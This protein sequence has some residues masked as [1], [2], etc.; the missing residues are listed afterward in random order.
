MYFFAMY[1][2][3]WRAESVGARPYWQSL[4]GLSSSTPATAAAAAF[5]IYFILLEII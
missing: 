4:A 3:R 2:Y 5:I 1:K